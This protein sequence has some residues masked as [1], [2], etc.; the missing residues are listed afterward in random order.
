MTQGPT[1][2][3]RA[4]LA[5][6]R[7]AVLDRIAAAARSAGRDPADVTLIAVTKTFPADDVVALADIGQ[8]DVGENR[9]Q[10]AASKAAAVAAVRDAHPAVADLRWHFVG[11]LQ[12]NKVASVVRYAD[13]VHSVD[14]VKLVTS[15]DRAAAEHRDRPLD[16][17]V[18]IDLAG[19]V[20]ARQPS[21]K[22]S[23]GARGGVVPA[24]L[25]ALAET[26]AGAT[27]LRLRGVMAVAPLGADP[28]EA[29]A[30][31]AGVSDRLRAEFPQAG[32]V[33]AGMSGDVEAAIAHGATHVRIGTA[34]LGGRTALR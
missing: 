22:A 21:P 13:L 8:R 9:D 4:E 31:L 27:A 34:L 17:L 12:R 25:L 18:Q 30:A 33:S 6:N 28:A 26:I 20:P 32:V 5:A 2:E 7:A 19:E 3:R 14:R 1:A 10:E 11:Q 16:V 29:F 24:D 15:L 23:I